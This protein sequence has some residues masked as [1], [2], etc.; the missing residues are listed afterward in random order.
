MSS[1]ATQERSGLGR[2]STS[3]TRAASITGPAFTRRAGVGSHAVLIAAVIILGFPIYYAFAGATQAAEQFYTRE[4]A[5]GGAL[6]DNVQRALDEDLLRFMVNSLLLA[7]VIATAKVVY[8]LLGAAALVYFNVPLKT[9]IFAVI[10]ATLLL[11]QDV[12]IIGL[13]RLVTGTFGLG[14]YLAVVVPS[15]ATAAGV[16][17]FRQ[18]FLRVPRSIAESAQLDGAGPMR[19]L[20]KILVPMSW[21]TIASLFMIMFLAGW[22]LY[23]WPLLVVQN[24]NEQ[25]V[26]AGLRR[27][28][29]A[30]DALG[31]APVPGAV[32][33]AALMATVPPLIVFVLLQKRYMSGFT[34][35]AGK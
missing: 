11:P 4:L 14:G 28:D 21:N 24:P 10:M 20:V 7:T 3:S 2:R 23:L 1:A 22:N 9:F 15:M 30:N 26:Q 13:F 32:L 16:F 33:A 34:L 29:L 31:I 25:V 17:V 12:L 35:T 27:I 5:P 8:G 18:H 6:G 19:F